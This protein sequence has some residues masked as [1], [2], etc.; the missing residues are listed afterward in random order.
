MLG[1]DE[2]SECEERDAKH[3][4]NSWIVLARRTLDR[5]GLIHIF[6][7]AVSPSD[8]SCVEEATA[9]ASTRCA[10]LYLL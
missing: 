3:K 2:C 6:V 1:G 8:E 10:S 5:L 7:G 9:S 4:A